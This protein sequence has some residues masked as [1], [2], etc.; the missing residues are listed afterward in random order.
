VSRVVKFAIVD[1]SVSILLLVGAYLVFPRLYPGESFLLVWFYAANLVLGP[2][3]F[4]FL[5]RAVRRKG[6]ATRGRV[7]LTYFLLILACINLSSLL[8]FQ[9]VY[10]ISLIIAVLTKPETRMT[11]IAELLNPVVSFGVAWF[12][13]RNSDMMGAA[14]GEAL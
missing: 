10:T 6:F 1:F 9:R 13:F 3:L 14:R 7:A 5:A 8:F 11:T 2:L 12:F 4:Y